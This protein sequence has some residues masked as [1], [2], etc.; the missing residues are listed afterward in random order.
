MRAWKVWVCVC[1]FLLLFGRVSPLA[2]A[3]SAF[4]I[5]AGQHNVLDG[6]DGDTAGAE[7]LFAPRGFHFLPG[8]VPPLAPVAGLLVA[9][10]GSLY[11]YGGFRLDVPL[12]ERW[13]A[14]SGFAAGLFHRGSGQELGGPIEFRSSI[15]LAYR[16]GDG[17][18][19]GL[20]LSHLSNGGLYGRNPGSESLVLVWS[21]GFKGHVLSSR[22]GGD[23]HGR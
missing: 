21:A 2:A 1:W 10:R 6:G 13:V 5:S 15:E 8:F 7:A 11:V 4:A 17:S 19:L 12:G 18:R 20:N 16:F 14:T 22:P 23:T 3:P 9:S